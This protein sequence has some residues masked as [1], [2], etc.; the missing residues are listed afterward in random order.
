MHVLNILPDNRLGGPQIRSRKI[1]TALSDRGIKTSFLVPDSGGGFP[2]YARSSGF[3]VH[4]I[5]FQRIRTPSKIRENWSFLRNFRSTVVK[6]RDIIEKSGHDVVHVNVSTNFQA[7]SATALSDASLVWHFN[8]TLT[9]T[10][11][12]QAAAQLA[13][14]WCDEV[15]VAA[16]AVSDYYFS[17]QR[18]DPTTVYAP[19]DTE[20]FSPSSMNQEWPENFLNRSD[21]PDVP[22]VGTIGNL[23]PA[24]GTEYFIRAIDKLQ[25]QFGSVIAPIVGR[26]LETRP[27][28]FTKLKKIVSERGL[29]DTVV[30]CGFRDDI[31]KVLNTFDVF[32]LSSVT[33]ACPMVVLEAMAMKRP[34]VASDVGGV[35]EQIKN[36]Q[37]GLIVPPGEPTAIADSVASILD[38]SSLGPEIG[39]N[40][41]ERVCDQFG[42]Q[43]IANQT[44]AVYER[45][46][47]I[48]DG[49]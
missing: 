2:E 3:N 35:R 16:D 37:H 27:G 19:V 34:V 43:T 24:K 28:Y 32:V 13:T 11:V 1:A 14:R 49:V 18:V 44:L 47:G 40:A 41:R 45:A 38:S 10:P 33:E 26:P 7:A 9:P 5:P 25:A 31:A 46:A 30:F 48:I 20:A 6:I 42:T 22:V 36:G 12:K 23:N 15:V 29:E 39:S 17:S 8:D 4:T 21:P